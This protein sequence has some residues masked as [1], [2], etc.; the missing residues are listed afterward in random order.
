MSLFRRLWLTVAFTTLVAFAGSFVV[1]MLTARHYLE[2]QLY[3]HSTDTAAALALTMSQQAKDEATTELL[4]S[5]LFDSGHF[6]KVS[7]RNVQGKVVVERVNELRI[8]NV[9]A[10]FAA[11]FPIEAR[12]GEALVSDGWQQAGKVVILADV[13][14]AY[15]A[16]WSGALRLLLWIVAA[17]VLTGILGSLILHTIR[18]PL[19]R[20]V[21][22][23][24]AITE[25][26]FLQLDMPRIPEL[27]AMVQA[28]NS[29]VVRLKSMFDEEA[30]RI[31][32]LQRQVNGD[33]L[34]GLVNKN[35]FDSR[36]AAA[37]ADEDAA[38]DGCLLWLHL[39]EL[40]GLNQSLGHERC[41][42]LL[43]EVGELWGRLAEG[44]PD[45]VAARLVGGE[46]MLLAPRLLPG[47]AQA[48]AQ[49]MVDRLV[50]HLDNHYD[51]RGNRVHL[52]I[53]VY[54]HGQSPALVREHAE[55]ALTAAIG[56][57]DNAV[58]LVDRRDPEKEAM[59]WQT[60]LARGLAERC[61]FLQSF[62]VVRADGTPLHE[63][64]ALRCAIRIPA[65]RCRPPPS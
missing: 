39:H 3:A 10:F 14:F 44:H 13:R 30:A 9:P 57:S 19:D 43:R 38:G 2:Q 5:A 24:G 21:E 55:Q 36:L 22:Q 27:R 8:D 15:A 34:T 11:V 47:E 17:G 50:A 32:D 37:L 40:Q 64:M 61:F 28:L 45:R 41:D 35:W 54:H 4:V 6:R 31:R 48:L 23:A 25:R 51:L 1:S 60:L 20:V 16:L 7:Y 59:P 42:A 33:A 56:D 53:A 62:P 63:E 26:R 49:G 65:C 18:Q 52:G 12:E 46:F 58:A 29:M